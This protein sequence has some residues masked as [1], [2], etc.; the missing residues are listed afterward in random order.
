MRLLAWVPLAPPHAFP[1][2]YGKTLDSLVASPH[3]CETSA[4]EEMA[5]EMMIWLW[6]RD[7]TRNRSLADGLGEVI[8]ENS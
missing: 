8:R 6:S 3:V 7:G 2:I 5:E 1:A 4:L